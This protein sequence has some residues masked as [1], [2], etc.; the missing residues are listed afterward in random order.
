MA[1]KIPAIPAGLRTSVA[2][3]GVM[4]GRDGVR[5]VGNDPD[6]VLTDRGGMR[7]EDVSRLTFDNDSSGFSFDTT[8]VWAALAIRAVPFS[9]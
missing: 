7:D 1:R 4:R 2:D 8:S 6:L 3:P 5:G 9:T